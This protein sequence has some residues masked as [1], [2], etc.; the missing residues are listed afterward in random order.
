MLD[1]RNESMLC[2]RRDVLHTEADEPTGK[3]KEMRASRS[4]LVVVLHCALAEINT[5]LLVTATTDH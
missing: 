2:G 3:E 5:T 1:E 4:A